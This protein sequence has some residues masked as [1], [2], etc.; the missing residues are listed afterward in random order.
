MLDFICLDDLNG[1]SFKRIEY[2]F[3]E[4]S[5]IIFKNCIDKISWLKACYSLQNGKFVSL[6]LEKE[7]MTK[8]IVMC[9][10]HKDYVSK[11]E[12]RSDNST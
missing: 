6:E 3:K 4:L 8:F 10:I 12:S 7:P 2:F 1:I 5:Y 9:Q 11:L